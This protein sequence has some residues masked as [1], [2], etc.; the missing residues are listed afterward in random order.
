[1]RFLFKF[2][3]RGRPESFKDS[4]TRHLNHLSKKN[5]YKFV[6]SFDNDD[7]SMKNDDILNFLDS[8]NINYEAFYGDNKTKIEAYNA[9]LENQDF[10]VLVLL[11]DDMIPCIQNYDEIIREIMETNENGLD[12]TIHFNT[13]RW[14]N[15]LDVWC[16]MGKK[17]YDRFGYI[18]HPDYKSIACDNEYTE[19]AKMLNRSIFTEISPFYHNNISDETTLKNWYFNTEDDQTY[20]RRKAI[21]F[22]INLD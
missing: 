21:N 14:V 18:Y 20:H 19:V 8:L 17:Y 10:D 16:V 9:N 2:A 4:L 15:L 22:E 1:M 6:F 13:S 3:S 7:P 11:Q 5:T 12:T